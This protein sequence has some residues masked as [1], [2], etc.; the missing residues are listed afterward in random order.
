MNNSEKGN[1]R[2][3]RVRRRID[4]RALELGAA[5]MI[6]IG[7]LFTTFVTDAT[8]QSQPPG[9]WPTHGF[10][11]RQFVPGNVS[12]GTRAVLAETLSRSGTALRFLPATGTAHDG[13]AEA[14]VHVTHDITIR[15]HTR[16]KTAVTDS[17]SALGIQVT[18]RTDTPDD[19]PPVF[20]VGGSGRETYVLSP[21]GMRD[22]SLYAISG[23][24]TLGDAHVGIGV[25]LNPNMYVMAGYVREKRTYRSGAHNWSEEEHFVG[26]ALRARW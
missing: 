25:Q 24:A 7:A 17:S 15:A 18:A 4:T 12:T 5:A 13:E 1:V 14:L 19:M 8:P 11:P 20:I 22:Y 6:S 16:P 10:D 2:G 9:T 26:L 3:K 21:H 23:E